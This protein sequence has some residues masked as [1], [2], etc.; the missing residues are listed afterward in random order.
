M[1][2]PIPTADQLTDT[3]TMRRIRRRRDAIPDLATCLTLLVLAASVIVAT[4]HS[5]TDGLLV[6]LLA[7]LAC[8]ALWGLTNER[9]ARVLAALA[10]WLH[11]Q[12]YWGRHS[13]SYI[14]VH[15]R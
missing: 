6:T 3:S 11:V 7:V 4:A 15:S 12:L 13:R 5:L 9:G 1:S 8:V 2:D 14:R 10:A